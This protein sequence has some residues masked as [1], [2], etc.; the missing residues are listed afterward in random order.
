MKTKQ[1]SLLVT[2][3][4]TA[5]L[6]VL[7][8]PMAPENW[9][10]LD[11]ERDN[12]YGVST[13]R[14]YLELLKDKARQTVVVAVIDGG[15]DPEHEDLKNVMW[16]N[17]GEIQGNGIDDDMNGY[18]D[19][20]Y[21]WNFI[22]GKDGKNVHHDTYEQTRIVAKLE[23]RFGQ[24]NPSQVSKNDKEQYNRYITLKEDIDK[25][26]E[27]A[28]ADLAQYEQILSFIKA[29]LSQAKQALGDLP[30]TQE[31]V[32]KLDGQK[33]GMVKGFF[34]Q[35]LPQ[36]E[37]FEG[38]VDDLE[39]LLV[40]DYEQAV[41]DE[42]NKVEYSYNLEFDPRQIVGDD[43]SNIREKHYGNPDV[44]GPDAFHGT[45][46]AGIIAA[47]RTNDIG[48]KGVADNVKIMAI[49]AV[50][51]GD[52]RDKDVANAIRYAVDNGA[53]I[54]NMSFGKGYSPD[55]KEVERAI[56][57]AEKN[58]VLLVHAA[59][60]SS[61]DN[62]TEPNFP[63]VTYDKKKGL[64]SKK[65]AANWIEVGALSYERGV[66]MV[67]TFSNYGQENVD[68]FAP[69]HMIYS[70]APDGH[71]K[72]ASGTSMASPVVSGVAAVIKS[73]F[74]D[75]SAKE[76]KTILTASARPYEGEVKMPGSGELVPFS[77]LSRTGGVVNL[78]SAVLQ[79]MLSS[80]KKAGTTGVR[81]GER[82]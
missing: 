80:N 13:E 61:D 10:N 65:R 51:D 11:P 22:G 76:L 34:A 69:G 73:H 41:E 15:V 58:N 20:V 19:D 5:N 48:I 55:E 49:R 46:V 82:S 70:T 62:D 3:C 8:Q 36:M 32:D 54:I 24:I 79:A 78:K 50:P 26:K 63:N 45:H 28:K 27:Q 68:L 71:Y 12:I 2:L 35:L 40:G 38:N 57:Y 33:Y 7:A 9:F 59:G 47:D 6:S 39:G 16:K 66:D 77:K 44:K 25:K 37:D 60:N 67:A 1:L 4:V 53:H 23:K 42:R 72:D 17:P 43:Y 74:P 52:E 31:N 14:T 64:F 21:G 75:I 81:S 18:V 30:V 56:R 29:A